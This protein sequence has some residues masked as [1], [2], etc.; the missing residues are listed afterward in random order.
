MENTWKIFKRSIQA[1]D[2]VKHFRVGLTREEAEAICAEHHYIYP[3]YDEYLYDL[4]IWEDDGN[5]KD[6]TY[7]IIMINTSC[8]TD[9]YVLETGLDAD[10]AVNMCNTKGWVYWPAGGWRYEIRIEMED[11]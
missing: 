5:H 9:R 8:V 7:R 2:V 3:S 10:D 1:P 6:P 11:E 4:E